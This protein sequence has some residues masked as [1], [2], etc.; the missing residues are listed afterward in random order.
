MHLVFHTAAYRQRAAVKGHVKPPW[1]LVRLSP[2]A[3]WQGRTWQCVRAL[4]EVDPE[5]KGLGRVPT[6][7]VHHHLAQFLGSKNSL[8]QFPGV[9]GAEDIY[10][11]Y[12]HLRG[13]SCPQ[14][15]NY[16]ELLHL[17]ALALW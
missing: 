17:V 5:G 12:R 13:P 16:G 3:G 9:A 8:G 14:R 10:T 6:H 15:D 7:T 11:G 2:R 1:D 4:A